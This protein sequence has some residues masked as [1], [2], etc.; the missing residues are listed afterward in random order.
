[1]V[2]VDVETGEITIERFVAVDDCGNVINPLLA[3]GQVHGGI[4][5]GIGQ[6]LFEGTEYDERGQLL[7]GFSDGLCHPT[8]RRSTHLRDRAHSHTHASQRLRCQG[9]R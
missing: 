2:E 8:S 4:A 1:M 3:T 7:T 6:A 5:Q 9:D